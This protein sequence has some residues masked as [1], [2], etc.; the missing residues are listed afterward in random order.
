M[1]FEEL[2]SDFLKLLKIAIKKI[3]PTEKI[4]AQFCKMI[5]KVAIFGMIIN[6]QE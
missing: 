5:F 2:M 3:F 1:F 6:K 4:K